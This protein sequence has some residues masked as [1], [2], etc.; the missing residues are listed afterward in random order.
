MHGPIGA[1]VAVAGIFLPGLLLMAGVLP[2][3]SRLRENDRARAALSGVNASV[4]GVLGAALYKPV[5]T[6]AVHAPI[7][8]AFALVAFLLLIQWRARPWTIVLGASILS[9]FIFG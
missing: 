2:Y 1:C 7:D 6:S 4:V 3:W 9:Q 8:L 5:W